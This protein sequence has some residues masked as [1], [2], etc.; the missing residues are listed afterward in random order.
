MSL[1]VVR[2]LVIALNGLKTRQTLRALK[3]PLSAPG[4]KSAREEITI[5]KSI[6]FQLLLK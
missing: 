4:T 2:D 3:E 5:M 6:V 1:N